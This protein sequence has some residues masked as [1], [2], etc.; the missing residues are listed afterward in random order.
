MKPTYVFNKERK[1][2]G[3]QCRFSERHEVTL[4]IPSDRD[5]FKANFVLQNPV[6]KSTNIAPIV[7]ASEC[8]TVGKQRVH[9]GMLHNEGGW[10][11]DVNYLDDEISVRYKRKIEKE[12]NYA[13]Q[14]GLATLKL[15]YLLRQNNAV[16]IYE[17]YFEGLEGIPPPVESKIE[18]IQL[19]KDPAEPKR[20]IRHISWSAD[21]GARIATAH[22][23]LGENPAASLNSYIWDVENPNVPLSIL[24]PPTQMLCLEFSPR[25]LPILCSGLLS[26]QVAIF[27]FRSP[28]VPS[29]VSIKDDSH[30]AAC[31]SIQWI[32][33]QSGQEF[34]SGG[35]D[36]SVL[37]WDCR[38]LTK[39]MERLLM[40][41]VKTDDQDIRRAY[42]VTV[43]E[44]ETTIPAKFMVGTKQG[45][46]FSCNRRGKTPIEKIHYKLNCH[47]GPVL[48]VGRNPSYVKTFLTVGDWNARLWSEDN[49]DSAIFWTKNH[50]AALTHSAWSFGRCSLFFISRADGT[51]DAW[52]I[53][54]QQDKPI[55]SLKI[56]DA[57]IECL[58]MRADSQVLAAGDENG[59][60]HLIRVSDDLTRSAKKDKALL[61]AVSD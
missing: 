29:A 58:Q 40:D 24:S 3:R 2:F 4:S 28:N 23:D 15:E 8:N 47:F 19:F 21:E 11:K 49:R 56:C 54:V 38:D 5:F 14:V 51:V 44:Y 20:P 57:R 34:F 18:Q 13:K 45:M 30:Q 35:A 17:Q 27:D 26:G 25:N 55:L 36:G 33:S 41:P 50:K 10:P 59:K 6:D 46:L 42:G 7:A 43:L 60:M 39:P 53:L 37:W 31:N 1:T 9:R 32:N 61:V 52:D 12:D 48:S 22:S 16:N